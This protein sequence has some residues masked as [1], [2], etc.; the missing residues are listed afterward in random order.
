MDSDP[1]ETLLSDMRILTQLFIN[2]RAAIVSKELMLM[3]FINIYLSGV[4]S[5]LGK[6]HLTKLLSPDKLSSCF[7]FNLRSVLCY[8]LF[9]FLKSI[10]PDVWKISS[11]M[12]IFSDDGSH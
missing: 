2:A 7:H 1:C 6:L 9:L 8:S 10:F 5:S 3:K 12:P 11:I 4:G